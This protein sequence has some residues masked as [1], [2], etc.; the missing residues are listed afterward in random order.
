MEWTN[1][2]MKCV[3]VR[4]YKKRQHWNCEESERKEN[5]MIYNT[6]TYIRV[7]AVRLNIS[8]GQ[9]SNT[10]KAKV[11]LNLETERERESVW[12]K[13][14]GYVLRVFLFNCR[15]ER[16]REKVEEA[17]SIF[18]IF[19][20]LGDIIVSKRLNHRMKRATKKNITGSLY[21]FVVFLRGKNFSDAMSAAKHIPNTL[22]CMRFKCIWIQT[23][24]KS[25]NNNRRER[26]IISSWKLKTQDSIW[27][28]MLMNYGYCSACRCE[29][30][31]YSMHFVCVFAAC[32]KVIDICFA[33]L[34]FLLY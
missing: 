7:N 33:L 32:Q 1:E 24:A 2:W 5:K 29:K 30:K 13:K 20:L 25:N 17:T 4:L 23:I 27:R 10:E 14:S 6:H 9:S 11:N 19:L 3:C 22:V 12:Q 31:V 15:D 26:K 21:D 8:S 16:K 34:S 18:W 28:W